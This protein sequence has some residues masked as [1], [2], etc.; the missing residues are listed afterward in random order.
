M[1]DA[2]LAVTNRLA[3]ISQLQYVDIDW[4]QLDYYQQNPPVKWPCALVDV[5]AVTWQNLPEGVQ[6]GNGTIR[7][8]VAD[9]Q[10]SGSHQKAPLAQ[11]QKAL[12]IHTL[13]SQVNQKLHT[14]ALLQHGLL[15][16]TS[17]RRIK[18]DDGVQLYEVLYSTNYTCKSAQQPVAKAAVIK[19]AVAAV[20]QLP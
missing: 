19:I 5:A 10:L 12:K 1:E 2:L 6:M 13:L 16:R 8:L 20:Q 17:T 4:G 3:E 7:V 11:R 15:T 9:V 14:W 18:R